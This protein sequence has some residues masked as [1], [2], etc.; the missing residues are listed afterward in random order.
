METVLEFP[1][2]KPNQTAKIDLRRFYFER[3]MNLFHSQTR[4]TIILLFIFA[5]NAIDIFS[6]YFAL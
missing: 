1:Q 6:P 2:F 3:A 4:L 5:G